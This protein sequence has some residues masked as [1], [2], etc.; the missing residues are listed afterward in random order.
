MRRVLVL[1]LLAG[2]AACGGEGELMGPPADPDPD[3][4]GFLNEA[5]ACP[6]QAEVINNVYDFDGC[7]DTPAEFYSAVRVDVENYWMRVLTG[8]LFTYRPIAAF[9]S[10]TTAIDTPC[11]PAE[12][13]N[14]F[15]CTIDEGVYYDVGF[16]Q[17]FLDGIGDMAPAFFISH[18]I[19]HH[20][21][22]ILGWAEP[23]ILS[24]KE[25][26][27]QAD[28]FAGAWTSDAEDRDQLEPR[29]LGEALGA[30]LAL[31]GPD[32]TWFDPTQ[33]GS[34]LQRTVAFGIGFD[35]GATACEGQEFR[36]LF[37]AAEK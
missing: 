9:L 22:K 29:D 16:L 32:D 12:L 28:C 10:Y 2:L 35:D 1:C 33:H 20:V 11:G 6:N 34:E 5:D 15:Y 14:A 4:D 26:E 36:G 7:P 19:G 3:N 17:L 18:E 27:L 31:G 21:S 24:T 37:P 23:G 25:Q 30:V 13:G 8:S